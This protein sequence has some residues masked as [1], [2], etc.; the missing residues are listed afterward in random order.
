MTREPPIRDK[1][2]ALVVLDAG[3]FGHLVQDAIDKDVKTVTA[4]EDTLSLGN[5][6][7]LL[8]RTVGLG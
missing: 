7:S 6:R 3:P 1:P 5:G 2:D 8:G 4:G